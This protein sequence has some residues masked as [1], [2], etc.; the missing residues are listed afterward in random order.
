MLRADATVTEAIPSRGR[1][2]R[3]L[4]KHQCNVHNQNN[5]LVMTLRANALFERRPASGTTTNT[6]G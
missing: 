6:A 3:G 2:D 4:V 1:T 5:E